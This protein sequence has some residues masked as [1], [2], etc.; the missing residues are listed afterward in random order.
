[1]VA[2]GIKHRFNAM[3]VGGSRALGAP[4]TFDDVIPLLLGAITGSDSD[5]VASNGA[6]STGVALLISKAARVLLARSSGGPATCDAGLIKAAMSQQGGE[7]RTGVPLV[8]IEDEEEEEGSVGEELSGGA[9]VQLPFK[10]VA[11]GADARL[12]KKVV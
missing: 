8:E 2:Y 12:A 9:T 3:T 4:I 5:P 11:G 7:E 6:A 1:M 10:G